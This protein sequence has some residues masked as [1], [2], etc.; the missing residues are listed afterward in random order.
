MVRIVPRQIRVS[1]FLRFCQQLEALSKRDPGLSPL[2]QKESQPYPA[3]TPEVW[4]A[5]FC[6]KILPYGVIILFQLAGHNHLVGQLRG[7]G[8]GAELL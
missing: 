4:L 8:G 2:L 5:V 7:F 3:G 6:S 1:L